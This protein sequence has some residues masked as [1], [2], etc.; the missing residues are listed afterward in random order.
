MPSR[1]LLDYGA[2]QFNRQATDVLWSPGPSPTTYRWFFGNGW[3]YWHRRA[4]RL[5]PT[6]LNPTT[7]PP[8]T[9]GQAYPTIA[10]PNA[11]ATDIQMFIPSNKQTHLEASG[12][13]STKLSNY[14]LSLY[15]DVTSIALRDRQWIADVLPP[16]NRTFTLAGIRR[17]YADLPAN[18]DRNGVAIT[19]ET[20]YTI[21]SA[22]LPL[23][24][25]GEPIFQAGGTFIMNFFNATITPAL[26][27]NPDWLGRDD[28][29]TPGRG[30]QIYFVDAPSRTVKALF[31]EP[32]SPNQYYTDAQIHGAIVDPPIRL[33]ADD[34]DPTLGQSPPR[35]HDTLQLGDLT[36]HIAAVTARI[37]RGKTIYHE[38]IVSRT[39]LEA[40]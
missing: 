39:V 2:R 33:S 17:D 12:T 21:R 5:N 23:H 16:T 10:I 19:D 28:T 35:R 14:I 38:V 3:D 18:P 29:S 25:D 7:D 34:F 13:G 36:L 31:T 26:A 6:N 22:S 8:L 9:T 1:N 30:T 11:G 20:I 4:P 40:N 27:I 32:I 37:H 24:P 15:P